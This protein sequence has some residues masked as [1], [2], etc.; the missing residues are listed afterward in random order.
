VT[1][2]TCTSIDTFGNDNNSEGYR[3]AH[4]DVYLVGPHF[5]GRRGRRA[6]AMVL[7]DRAMVISY[8]SDRRN[9]SDGQTN[10]RTDG[11]NT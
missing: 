5:G 8:K 7:F 3:C 4:N 2:R 6:S 9:G 1:R 11:C 10:G